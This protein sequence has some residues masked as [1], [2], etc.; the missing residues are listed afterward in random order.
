MTRYIF[1]GLA[2]FFFINTQA[3]VKRMVL[4]KYCSIDAIP[5][6]E[7]SIYPLEPSSEAKAILDTILQEV[8]IA[9][10]TIQLYAADVEMA[11]ALV[12]KNKRYIIYDEFFVEKAKR[13]T[14]HKWIVY[15]VFAH[16]L[17]H[18][19]NAHGL[20]S[21]ENRPGTELEADKFAAA[22]LAKLGANLD[23][24]LAAA[25]FFTTKETD[26]HPRKKTRQGQ[27]LIGWK[28]GKDQLDKR[29]RKRKIV[30]KIDNN[31]KKLTSAA[32][33]YDHFGAYTIINQS[34]R[35]VTIMVN[36]NIGPYQTLPAPLEVKAGETAYFPQLAGNTSFRYRVISGEAE[37][38]STVKR[39][40]ILLSGQFNVRK[41]YE[42]TMV[43]KEK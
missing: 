24:T 42:H 17:A 4:D 39:K 5:L 30:A 41:C 32:C 16:E 20:D 3:Q 21:T 37:S 2:L 13:A 31:G 8:P 27:I 23:Q 9:K 40:Q 25:S 43:I 26:T 18:H 12:H 38:W 11:I 7:K 35:D 6:E 33:M 10:R 1:C 14:N 22:T 29:M 28:E 15:F 19:L 36:G 34:S